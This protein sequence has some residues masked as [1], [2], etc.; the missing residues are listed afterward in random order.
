M[1]VPEPPALA[2]LEHIT[3]SIYEASLKC[4]AKAAWFALGDTGVLPQH[5]ASI[6]GS[7]FHAVLAAAHNGEFRVATVIDRSQARESF[8]KTARK[9]HLSAHGLVKLKFPSA[10]RLPFYYLTRERAARSAMPIA[11]SRL[12]SARPALR[13]IRLGSA[14][15]RTETRFRS[16][17]GRLVGRPDHI[18]SR[19]GVI[20]D[21][22]TGHFSEAEVF[23]VSDP[24][25]RQLRLYA[26]L[27]A[28]NGIDIGK[29][30]IVRGDGQRL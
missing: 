10:D 12:Q 9:L 17:N 16:K 21:Y 22:K 19:S 29:G 24:E 26:F 30:A 3:P 28:E 8:D 14:K 4:L 23:T 13:T 11:K 27:A 18:D 2:Q 25:A 20:V 6:L 5:P 1:F 7:A 15:V